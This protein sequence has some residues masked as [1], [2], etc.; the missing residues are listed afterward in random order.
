VAA[1]QTDGAVPATLLLRGLGRTPIISRIT[2]NNKNVVNTARTVSGAIGGTFG[3]NAA[4]DLTIG[5]PDLLGGGTIFADL[6]GT[7]AFATPSITAAHLVI[8]AGMVQI[9]FD[10]TLL[11]A[12]TFQLLTSNSASGPW[13][14]D[15]SAALTTTTPGLSYRFTTMAGGAPAQFF[16]IIG[17]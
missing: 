11:P 9:D 5:L 8:S 13:V 15:T 16:R 1:S 6:A 3:S 7:L 4:P 12:S 17:R 14:Q 10:V 2:I